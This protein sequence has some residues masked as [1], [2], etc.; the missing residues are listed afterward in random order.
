MPLPFLAQADPDLAGAGEAARDAAAAAGAPAWA[1]ALVPLL[2]VAAG[3]L[4]REWLARRRESATLRA[5]VRGVEAATAGLDPRVARAAKSVIAGA[6]SDAGVQSHLSAVVR[7]ET[8]GHEAGKIA[9]DGPSAAQ[10][11]PAR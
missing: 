9:G 6:A 5:V 2:V 10:P 4:L 11:G 1:Q 8:S 3:A 7:R